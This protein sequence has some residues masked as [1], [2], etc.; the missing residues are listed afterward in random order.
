MVGMVDIYI[1]MV[2]GDF[3]V[4]LMV[5]LMGFLWFIYEK[6]GDLMGFNE[7]WWWFNRIWLGSNYDLCM[8]DIWYGCARD[9][10]HGDFCDDFMGYV[11][12]MSDGL[13]FRWDRTY[14]KW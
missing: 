14:G 1:Y 2:Y 8:D 4:N 12:S 9:D 3:M 6:Y 10:F 7:I 5:I 13:G 11:L